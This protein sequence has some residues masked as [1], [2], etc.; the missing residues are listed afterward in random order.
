MKRFHA[1]V[2][3]HALARR[4]A[5]GGSAPVVGYDSLSFTSSFG[6]FIA[7]YNQ[8]GRI[9]WIARVVG[10][11]ITPGLM[12]TDSLGNIIVH[13][14]VNT[15][16]TA[17][18]SD[19]TPFS[20]L[21]PWAG[22]SDIYLVKYSP[23]GFV[24][25]VAG[26]TGSSTEIMTSQ[27]IDTANNIYLCGYGS[28]VPL[29]FVGTAGTTTLAGSASFITFLT[30]FSPAGAVQW[31]FRVITAGVISGPIATDSGNNVILCGSIGTTSRTFRD[32]GSGTVTLVGASA[33]SGHILKY[34]TDGAIQW[35]TVTGVPVTYVAID[36]LNNIV[37][38]G[39]YS[40]TSTLTGT[41]ATTVTL[42]TAGAADTYVARYSPAGALLWATSIGG[43]V[44]ETPTRL[45][46]DSS[47]NIYVVGTYTSS[48][49]TVNGTD[50]GT[51]TLANGGSTDTYLVKYNA[52]GVIQWTNNISGVTGEISGCVSIDSSNNVYLSGG[53]SSATLTIGS[54]TLT[55]TSPTFD[56]YF[57]K[58]NSAGAIQWV[59]RA[60]CTSVAVT[61]TAV[62]TPSATTIVLSGVYRGVGTFYSVGF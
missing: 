62:A 10:G 9:L 11:S 12:T 31:T 4:N 44:A 53:F 29:S 50:G 15:Q 33:T 35:G 38:T 27:A 24:S 61:P 40:T 54:T 37:I 36:S 60:T 39:S 49:V 42:T 28:S 32:N 21:V 56:T 7:T 34:D 41:D 18:N 3:A 22:T 58:Y 48:S 57:V 43:T 1:A 45:A 23:S 55:K 8:A 13:G 16:A 2:A 20:P 51:T 6:H 52:A 5:G 47:N 26:I 46:V 17:Y 19:T 25:W 14:T 59:T 30:K